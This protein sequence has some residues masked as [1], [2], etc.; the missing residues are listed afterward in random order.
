MKLWLD[1]ADIQR[2][3][4]IELRQ[5]CIYYTIIYT[6][7][8]GCVHFLFSAIPVARWRD[9]HLLFTAE[10]K[11]EFLGF[12]S[13][14]WIKVND[15]RI[16]DLQVGFV[17]SQRSQSWKSDSPGNFFMA[18]TFSTLCQGPNQCSKTRRW[19]MQNDR[20]DGCRCGCLPP[21]SRCRNVNSSV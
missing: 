5:I 1:V 3:C 9:Y 13:W 18:S 11:Q 14:T 20:K 6:Y 15:A 19:A 7:I 8:Q 2:L 17:S 4:M 10:M 16:S 21:T 12:Q